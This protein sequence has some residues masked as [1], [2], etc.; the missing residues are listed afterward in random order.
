MLYYAGIVLGLYIL[1]FVIAWLKELR[2]REQLVKERKHGRTK[3]HES[4]YEGV[5]FSDDSG[6]DEN[7]LVE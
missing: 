2:P 5:N 3:K 7:G 1:Y 4:D 6:D